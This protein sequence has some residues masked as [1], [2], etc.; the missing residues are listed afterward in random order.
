VRGRIDWKYALALELTDAGFD[1]SVLSEFRTRLIQGNAEAQVFE[2]MLTLFR[3]Q[4]LLKAR[5]RQRTDSP[6]VLAAIQT[7]NRLECIGE[8]VRHALNRV[9]TGAPDWLQAWVPSVWFD[10]YSRRFEEY[11]LPPGKGERYA[12]AEEIGTDGRALLLAIYNPA[13]PLWLRDLPAVQILRTVWIQPFYAAD[14]E[15]HVRW[16]TAEDLPPAALLISSPYDPDARDGRKR[17]T[18]WTG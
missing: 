13:A 6:H 5:G 4:G 15:G 18:Q 7:L 2:S 14:A 8:T 16:R 9:A 10:R 11:R 17:Q 1:A 3:E 12:L